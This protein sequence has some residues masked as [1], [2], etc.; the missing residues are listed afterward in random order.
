MARTKPGSAQRTTASTNG[1]FSDSGSEDLADAPEIEIPKPSASTQPRKPSSSNKAAT[2]GAQKGRAPS[3]PIPVDEED[4]FSGPV[5]KAKQASTTKGKGKAPPPAPVQDLEEDEEEDVKMDD[6]V[7]ASASRGTAKSN[8]VRTKAQPPADDADEEEFPGRDTRSLIR[9]IQLLRRQKERLVEQHGRE[10]EKLHKQNETLVAD[11]EALREERDTFAKQFDN[12]VRLRTT[13]EEAAL[14]EFTALADERAAALQETIETLLNEKG[15]EELTKPG[16]LGITLF[17]R[18]ETDTVRRALEGRV[19]EKEDEVKELKDKIQE[20]E[21]HGKS[22]ILYSH[23]ASLKTEFVAADL[24]SDIENE[25]RIAQDEINRLQARERASSARGTGSSP[26]SKANLPSR[27]AA[28]QLKLEKEINTF[29]Q[30]MTG[31]TILSVNQEKQQHG[32]LWKYRCLF[33][34]N[35]LDTLTFEVV[36]CPPEP[37]ASPE[38]AETIYTPLVNIEPVPRQEF[39]DEL[40]WLSSPFSF[41]R[42]QLDMLGKSLLGLGRDDGQQSDQDDDEDEEVQMVED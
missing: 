15:L 37:G 19:L 26:S 42:F 1:N 4:V 28:D 16:Q 9:E 36:V 13:D 39:L 31:V 7:P 11:N 12:L 22:S 17:T 21:K 35:K 33:T 34:P 6:A 40:N 8:G 38:Q 41:Q 30:D 18:A 3:Q 25:R 23:H 2:K 10:V 29:L 5:K 32:T 24:A 14:Q 20:L 27:I